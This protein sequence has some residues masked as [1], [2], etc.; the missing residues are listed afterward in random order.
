MTM[1]YI[2]RI[3]IPTVCILLSFLY[4]TEIV[5]AITWCF[6]GGNKKRYNTSGNENRNYITLYKLHL[7]THKLYAL[8]ILQAHAAGEEEAMLTIPLGILAAYMLT[9]TARRTRI[10]TASTTTGILRNE[11]G[12][13]MMRSFTSEQRRMLCAIVVF[14]PWLGEST[15]A[16]VTVLTPA[17]AAAA[18]AVSE[19]HGGQNTCVAEGDTRRC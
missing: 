8:S 10:E 11:P 4:R 7:Q 3:L 1:I 19:A 2:L 16:D 6:L 5:E 13:M 9:R 17:P 14:G 15:R 18:R 12:S